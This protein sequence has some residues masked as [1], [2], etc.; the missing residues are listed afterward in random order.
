ML[1]LEGELTILVI[2]SES[3]KVERL[4]LRDKPLSFLKDK[5]IFNH[6]K[7][8]RVGSMLKYD[9]LYYLALLS[10]N[11]WQQGNY[12]FQLIFMTA[13]LN[14]FSKCFILTMLHFFKKRDRDKWI[15]ECGHYF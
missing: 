2:E 10:Q 7:I 9:K 11:A 4:E 3:V 12:Q 14:F 6:N 13:T 15:L 1:T 5:I 8:G